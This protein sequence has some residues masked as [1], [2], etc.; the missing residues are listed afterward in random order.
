MKE[1]QFPQRWHKQGF[2]LVEL[3]VCIG[4][5]SIL[6]G[7]LLPAVQRIR[8]TA[9]RLQCVNRLRQIGLA[10]CLQVLTVHDFCL[11]SSRRIEPG[12]SRSCRRLSNRQSFA[13]PNLNCSLARSCS[14]NIAIFKKQCP[15]FPVRM[16]PGQQRLRFPAIVISRQDFC[17]FR[18]A[19]GSTISPATVYCLL[20]VPF[21][22]EISRMDC[23]IR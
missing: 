16:I 22:S 23:R 2:T 14:S 7:L 21:V 13:M 15:H 1:P 8:S 9:S 12:R 6:M 3:M 11:G 17:H 20:P 18:D 4:I 10:H 19:Q 5:V